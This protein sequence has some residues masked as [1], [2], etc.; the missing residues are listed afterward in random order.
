M[1]RQQSEELWNHALLQASG[2]AEEDF[3]EAVLR[4]RK[5]HWGCAEEKSKYITDKYSSEDFL[6]VSEVTAISYGNLRFDTIKLP[7]LECKISLLQYSHG[8]GFSHG[9]LGQSQMITPKPT[10]AS[11]TA[12][13]SFSTSTSTSTSTTTA[14]SSA[15]ESSRATMSQAI[16]MKRVYPFCK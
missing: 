15:A 9:S 8:E 14:T 7:K 10:T 1:L 12:A 13:L 2:Y 5:L 4:L 3:V 16:P 6:F 11:V